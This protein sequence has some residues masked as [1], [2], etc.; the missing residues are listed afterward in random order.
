MNFVPVPLIW[1]TAA[2]YA[3]ILGLSDEDIVE[4]AEGSIED[5][6]HLENKVNQA[7][8]NGFVKNE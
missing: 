4:I 1:F 7:W 2:L 5:F 3:T 8:G 6:T